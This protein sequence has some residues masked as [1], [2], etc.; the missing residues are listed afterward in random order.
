[1]ENQVIINNQ[2]ISYLKF[3]PNDANQ[4]L[5]FLH[6]WRSQKE[7]WQPIIQKLLSTKPALPAGRHLSLSIALYALDLPGFG[8][9]P[10]PVGTWSVGD[11]AE[12]VKGFL[13]KLGLK[14]VVLAGHSF[15][16]R[17]G[18]KLAAKHPASIA[19][20]VLVDSAGF[21]M[22]AA[23]KSTMNFAAKIARP[24]FKPKFMQGLRRKIYQQ[25]GAG[26]YVATP[27]LQ[28][29]FVNITS[30]D[31]TED[32]K[33]IKTPTLIICGENDVETPIAYLHKMRSLIPDTR[34]LILKN[35]G[36]FSFLDEPE[37]FAD[38]VKNF[39]V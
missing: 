38:L 6:G 23:K 29:I 2:L 21:A 36:H 19:R 37:E 16:G 17:V 14:N 5:V 11:Y 12:I 31:L 18:I 10:A 32:M 39:V 1:M 26:D 9:S 34:Y 8:K 7:V 33:N 24:F 28:Q 15:G 35:A 4:S 13:E 25:I 30:E 3:G 22:D 27:E 20:L